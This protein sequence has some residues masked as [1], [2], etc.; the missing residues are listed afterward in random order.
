MINN[1]S[2]LEWV[3]LIR[4]RMLDLQ[5]DN[6]SLHYGAK[7]AEWELN[8]LREN[9]HLLQV[10]RDELQTDNHRL[11]S[12]LA[13]AQSDL[14]NAKKDYEYLLSVHVSDGTA[15]RVLEQANKNLRDDVA[16][17]MIATV[18]DD[19]DRLSEDNAILHEALDGDNVGIQA[20]NKEITTLR[21]DL[22]AAVLEKNDALRFLDSERKVSSTR[23]KEMQALR[24]DLSSIR[25][26]VTDSNDE[27]H[28]II[29]SLK[30]Q[31]LMARAEL[32]TARSGVDDLDAERHSR[33]P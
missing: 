12:A 29:N 20:L 13:F 24:A 10:E 18:R 9:N 25:A 17:K 6:E 23:Y 14:A 31:L 1:P 3:D 22:S 16:R 26:T 7:S 27:H 32:D 21:T 4:D 15:I 19:Y 30:Y 33:L 11:F 2:P 5:A 28:E 8:T